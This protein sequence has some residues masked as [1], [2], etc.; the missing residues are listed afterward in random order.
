APDEG[1]PHDQAGAE[2]DEAREPFDGSLGVHDRSFGEMPSG[3][4]YASMRTC[5]TAAASRG[6]EGSVSRDGSSESRG[7]GE[8]AALDRGDRLRAQAITAPPA[9][10]TPAGPNQ[11]SQFTPRMGGSRRTNSPDE[12]AKS[13]R[14]CS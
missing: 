11:T 14:I 3:Q 6:S 2:N 4:P 13:A 7:S 1:E 12:R 9:T 8:A 10:R 5:R